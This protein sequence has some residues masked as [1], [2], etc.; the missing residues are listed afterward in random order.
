MRLIPLEENV[1]EASSS[2]IHPRHKFYLQHRL[3]PYI[4]SPTTDKSEKE[5]L[6]FSHKELKKTFAR[7]PSSF[8][9]PRLKFYLQH[10]LP[11][12]GEDEG[13]DEKETL[14]FSHKKNVSGA[15]EFI[16]RSTPQFSSSAAPVLADPLHCFTRGQ[17]FAAPLSRVELTF[18]VF[19]GR[20]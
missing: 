2:F 13:K 18:K 17:A 9:H 20:S 3:L 4:V 6:T 12:N 19:C 5:P 10:R 15:S 1:S 11:Y 16:H 7:H 14:T 8:I